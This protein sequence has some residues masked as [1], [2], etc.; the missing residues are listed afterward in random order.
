MASNS[1]K[2]IKESEKNAI[3]AIELAKEDAEKIVEKAK[4]MLKT[5]NKTSYIPLKKNIRNFAK[6]Q[7]LLL[8]QILIKSETKARRKF[9]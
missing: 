6:R 1:I 9:L 5:K 8:A 4:K 3:H 7:K 2:Y